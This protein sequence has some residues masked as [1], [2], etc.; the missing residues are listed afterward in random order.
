[1]ELL[2]CPGD[3]AQYVVARWTI[4]FPTRTPPNQKQKPS[5]LTRIE[6]LGSE[7]P[8]PGPFPWP[9]LDG[10]TVFGPFCGASMKNLQIG[11]IYLL[12]H[13]WC[14][15]FVEAPK[16]QAPL[17][18]HS[19]SCNESLFSCGPQ[20]QSANTERRKLW[21][22]GGKWPREGRTCVRN[23]CLFY[24]NDHRI[25]AGFALP[26]AVPNFRLVQLK[27][28]SV[29]EAGCFADQYVMKRLELGIR[30]EKCG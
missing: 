22:V 29:K 23:C 28:E 26:V 3:G 6:S 8:G 1:M 13:V 9:T 27:T 30:G 24:A 10:S 20:M 4:S 15:A 16:L 12:M 25:A 19:L 7:R 2:L 5:H 18:A 21:K 11:I 17:F 14:D